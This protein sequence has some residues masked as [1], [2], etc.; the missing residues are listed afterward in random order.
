M[1]FVKP[2]DEDQEIKCVFCDISKAFKDPVCFVID[3]VLL[4][5]VYHTCKN[6]RAW[7][8]KSQSRVVINVFIVWKSRRYN[9]LEQC[10]LIH[11]YVS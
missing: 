11:S 4:L 8:K 10:D 7:L 9:V 3:L 5:C 1:T 6:L 2:H